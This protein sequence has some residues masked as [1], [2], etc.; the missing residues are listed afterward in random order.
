MSD[1]IELKL[2]LS[3]QGPALLIEH[4]LL[5]TLTSR[6]VSLGNQYYDTAESALR[7]RRVA[8]RVRRQDE[9][10]LQTLKS[11]AQSHGGLSS[12]GEWEWPLDG[13]ECNAAGLD[14]KGLRALEHPALAGLALETLRPVFTTDFER[15]LWHYRDDECDIEIALDQGTIDVGAATLPIRELELEL[16]RGDPACLWTL[17]DALCAPADPSAA[18]LPARPANHSKA[19]RASSLATRWPEPTA[20]EHASVD[21]LIDAIDSWQ[22]SQDRAWLANAK[23]QCERLIQ[24]WTIDDD[25]SRR[26]AGERILAD[27]QEGNLPWR[28]RDWLALR[29]LAGQAPDR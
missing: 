4:P 16:K 12:R 27:L 20:P 15:R 23:A 28:S 26:Q 18:P 7:S 22:D 13:V 10:R 24:R 9:R 14:V 3:S 21:S 25:T 5:R 17:A 8:L 19:S 11:A 2:A 29:Q 6:T 1:E